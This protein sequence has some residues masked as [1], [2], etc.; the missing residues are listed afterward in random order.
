MYVVS[1]GENDVFEAEAILWVPPTVTAAP[2]LYAQ[3]VASDAV[4]TDTIDTL[5]IETTIEELR[6]AIDV[7]LEGTLIFLR[8]RA[9]EP[10]GARILLDGIIDRSTDSERPLVAGQPPPVVTR[11]P[12]DPRQPLGDNAGR[13]AAVAV[14]TVTSAP[15]ATE[16]PA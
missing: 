1:A 11:Q 3:S 4:L 6:A 13:N 5:R 16:I 9:T 8:G 12:L 2:E 15:S 10:R 14:A 7:E